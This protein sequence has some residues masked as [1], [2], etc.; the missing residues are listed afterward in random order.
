LHL[1]PES[2]LGL[3]RTP[4]LSWRDKLALATERF[5]HVPPPAEEESVHDFVA[6][7]TNAA[8]AETFADALVTGI[9]AGDPT[10]LS[11][12]AA[13]P[14]LVA[15]EREHGRVMVGMKHAAKARRAAAQARG[16][17]GKGGSQL[18]SF[19]QGLRVLI[20]TLVTKL[21]Q[22]PRYGTAV[23]ALTLGEQ[24]R[25]LVQT[26]VETLSADAV[27]LACPAPV[28]AWLLAKVDAEL[29]RAVGGIPYCPVAVLALGYRQ[30]DVP[31][32][33]GGFGYVMP[34]RLRGDVLG[35]QWCSSIFPDRAPT[36]HVL[37]RVIAGGCHRPDV[38]DWADGQLLQTV[39]RHLAIALGIQAPPVFHH[40]V[41][42]QAAIPQY[43]LGHVGRVRQIERLANK[44]RGLF[45]AGNAYHGVALNDCTEQA[46]LVADRFS[47]S[48]THSKRGA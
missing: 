14:R 2:L 33:L 40:V 35:A 30:F 32:P 47:A 31:H 23:N 21:R 43:V 48:L 7:R 19:R 25:W 15:M 28:Q 12:E 39:R 18:R 6:R 34:Q 44:H 8:I 5:R 46:R 17:S 45:L 20:E 10:L 1:L 27:V 37:L 3:V 13:F 26:S 38:V 29:A 24:D 4:L 36:G 16:E 9:Y 41:R 11:A 22:P 42:W